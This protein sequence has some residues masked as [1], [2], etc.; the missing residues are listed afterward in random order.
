MA[1]REISQS[2]YTFGRRK[3]SANGQ[4]GCWYRQRI[5][6]LALFGYAMIAEA[7]IPLVTTTPLRETGVQ[8]GLVR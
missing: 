7:R 8:G 1:M 5:S 3:E 2:L 4:E 6:I